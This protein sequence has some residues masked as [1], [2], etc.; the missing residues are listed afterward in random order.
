[1]WWAVVVLILVMYGWNAYRYNVWSSYDG[2]GHLDYALR[3]AQGRGVP[4]PHANYLAWHEPGYYWL[5]GVGTRL[6]GVLTWAPANIYKL[7]QY[8]SV[9]IMASGAMAAGILAWQISRRRDFAWL[10][11]VATASLFCWSALARYVT[12]EGL[13]QAGILWWLVWFLWWRMDEPPQWSRV[14]WTILGLGLAGLLWIKLTAAVLVLAVVLWLLAQRGASLQSKIGWALWLLV[15]TGSLYTPW[16]YHKQ[17]MY[18]QALTINNYEQVTAPMPW[19]FF[20]RWDGSVLQTPFWTSGRGSFASM[21]SASALVDYDNIFEAYD[22]PRAD[23]LITGNG[24]RLGQAQ[25]TVSVQLIRWSLGLELWLLVGILLTLW[26]WARGRLVASEQLLVTV[27][28]SLGLALVYNVWRYPFLERGTLKAIFIAAAFPLF[29]IVASSAWYRVWPNRSRWV[30]GIMV[31]Y[32][33]VWLL[34][35]WRIGWLV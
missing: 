29:A 10:T 20:V 26:Q 31:L 17:K 35:S 21:L 2:G 9:V 1:M 12:N 23:D 11:G 14:K 30:N 13:L 33:V 7:W 16:L 24:R 3:L 4:E 8:V 32:W 27:A 18:G 28:L 5:I 19:R 34:L 6:M 15:L 25:A 22:R